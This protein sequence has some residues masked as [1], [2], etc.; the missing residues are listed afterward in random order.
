MCWG[1]EGAKSGRE[2]TADEMGELKRLVHEAM[3][4]GMMGWSCQRLGKNSI[5]AD[6]D[7]TPM[8]TDLVSPET[9]YAF[10][11]V[12]EERGEGFV[13]IINATDGDPVRN[14]NPEDRHVV[15]EIARRSNR[16]V[17]FNAVLAMD[18]PGCEEVHTRAIAWLNRCFEQGLQVYGQGVTVRAPFPVHLGAL[19]PIRFEPGL[20]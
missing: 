2:P 5:Q 20:E 9:L 4:A 10:A 12:L 3:D 8:P 17:L 7:G 19:E 16:P 6:F 18:D 14:A 15:E 13:E 11:D 1:L